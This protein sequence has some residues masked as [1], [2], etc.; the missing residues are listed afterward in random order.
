MTRR[1]SDPEIVAHA[2]VE[3]FGA[4]CGLRLRDVAGELGAIVMDIDSRAYDGLLVRVENSNHGRIG[5][6]RQ[7]PVE[8]R[9]RFT[10]GHE[11][12]HYLLGHGGTEIRCKPHDIENWSPILNREERDANTFA[13]EV[14]MPA[15]I[16]APLVRATPDFEIVES[17][18]RLCRT[19]ITASAVR[20]VEL[21]T[22]QIAVVWSV[23]GRVTWYRPSHELRRAI[24][25]GPLSAGTL[26]ASCARDGV[27]VDGGGRVPASAWCY[28]AGLRP[29][30]TV[31][32]WSRAMPR[33][34][35]VLTLLY[36]PDFLEARTG[37]EEED[38][39]ELD[40]D[41]FT[42]GRRRWR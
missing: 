23:G 32:E 30:A 29:D 15:S 21:S 8:G 37:Y 4:D 13:A 12:G 7:I 40:P 25:V 26:A 11:L 42:L 27:T 5:I 39:Q 28:E 3:E 36:A 16:I 14:L 9:K 17:I 38:E 1:K 41:E 35:G 31:I 10:A 19:S 33:Y 18:A 22:F 24:R 34:G 6:S 2:V 20:L